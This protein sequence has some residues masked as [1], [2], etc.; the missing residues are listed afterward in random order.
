MDSL[1]RESAGFGTFSTVLKEAPV[2]AE[3][4]IFP[5]EDGSRPR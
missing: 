2:A 3:F 1:M 5:A 4:R